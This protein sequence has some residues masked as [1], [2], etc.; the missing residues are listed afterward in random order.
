MRPFQLRQFASKIES[1]LKERDIASLCQSCP[2]ITLLRIVAHISSKWLR[3]TPGVVA[4]DEAAVV[5]VDEAAAAAMDGAVVAAIAVGIVIVAAEVSLHHVDIGVTASLAVV[6]GAILVPITEEAHPM[7]R[8]SFIIL[9]RLP[10][11]PAVQTH[12]CY[13]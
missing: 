8:N 4:V 5:A 1:V 13:F 11:S 12:G 9:S 6:A 2:A 7:T 3:V 10:V